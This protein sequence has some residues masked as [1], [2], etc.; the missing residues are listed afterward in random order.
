MQNKREEVLADELQ[1]ISLLK[2]SPDIL[3]RRPELLAE[4]EVP[5]D[6]GGAVSLIERQIGVLRE[7]NR[8]LDRRLCELMDVARDNERLA[9]SRHRIATNLLGAHD[10]DDVVSIVLDE[11][12]N[13][14]KADF[15]VIRL[16]TTSQVLL[17]QSPALF[18]SPDEDGLNVFKTMR[19][20]KNPVCGRSTSE[21]KK[22]LFAGDADSIES[23]AI[24]PLFAGADLG[25]IGLGSCDGSRFQ[26]TMGTQFLS[27]M[28]ELVSAALAVHLELND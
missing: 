21:Q 16:F 10:L 1:L 12:G 8:Q 13:E 7:K 19:E 17:E 9:Q 2:Q 6:S 14:L 11:L 26:P 28:G 23:A 18:L 20:Q 15:A 5:H 25:L 22:F 3:Q 27:Q 24:I 4:L